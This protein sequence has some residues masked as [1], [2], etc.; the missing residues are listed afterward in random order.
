MSVTPSLPVAPSR[1]GGIVR[2]AGRL[3]PLGASPLVLFLLVM[4]VAPVCLLVVYSFWQAGFFAVVHQFTDANYT[5]IFEQS[6]YWK[7][8]LKSLGVGFLC[9]TL[10][11]V[12][13]FTMA[14]AMTFRFGRFGPRILVLVMATL[15][16]SFVV[17][18]YAWKTILGTNGL[19]NE[20][21]LRLDIISHPLGFLLYGYFAIIV[22][23]VYVYLPIVVLPIYAGLQDIDPRVLEASRD[24]GATPAE[25]FRKVTLP[26][27]M[28][29]IRVGFAFAFVLSSSDYITP[30]LVGGFSGQMVGN[31]IADQ[32]GGSSNYPLGAA[33]SVALVIGFGIVFGLLA[34]VGRLVRL[35]AAHRPR[36]RRMARG[37]P[38]TLPRTIRRVP[39]SAAAT[40]VLLAYLLAPLIVVM[41]FSFNDSPVPG[42]PF[43]G[44]TIEWYRQ[45]LGQ[46]D[47]HRVL[48][49]SATVAVAAVTVALLIG[50]PAAFALTRRRFL[51][52]R[53][54]GLAI[55]GPIVVPGVVI[56]VALLTA[57]VYLNVIL[58]VKATIFAH[59]L[60]IVP[61][62]VLVMRARLA[63]MDPRIEEA[64]RDL[65]S[66]PLRVL[67]T[68][69]LPQILPALLGA[70]ILGIAISLD[71][72]VVTNFTIGADATIPTWI[73][74]QMRTGLT[75]AVNAV[76]VMLLVV[77][78]SL[79]G[80]AAAIIRLRSSTRLA[81][82]LGGGE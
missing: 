30:N 78:L 66:R 42:I 23:L 14:Y 13:G 56:G 73:F 34:L 43:R 20:A 25:T 33:L 21:L 61:Y 69:T 5:A 70:A 72:L 19:L 51:L 24:L 28:P 44:F 57:C 77:P 64:G 26:L 50:V 11:V 75:P 12:F 47:F 62:V 48:Q 74:G 76:A 15:L 32:F 38:S 45:V 54:V 58:G 10:M 29:A 17:R 65:G 63:S 82:S 4:L 71:E 22:T 40:G 27:A 39:W 67:R 49:T 81:R 35:L 46:G 6:I 41:L 9:G 55:Y 1:Q 16:S 68:V 2:R 52:S 31:V 7:L 8:L 18:I 59:A 3:L 60:L 53:A 79:M 36:R 80:I 37:A